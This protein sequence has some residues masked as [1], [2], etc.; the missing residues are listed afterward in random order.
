MRLIHGEAER[1][2][3]ISLGVVAGA[4]GVL[5]MTV[6]TRFPPERAVP[7]IAVAIALVMWQR[8]LLAWR[9]L[10]AGILLV[11]F[12]LPIRYTIPGNLPFELEPYRLLVA[13][14]L[15]GWVSALLV[16][17]RVRLRASGFEGPLLMFIVGAVAS[18]LVNWSQVTSLGVETNVTKS[19]TFL[20]SFVL[21]VYFVTSV[22]RSASD[23]NFVLRALVTCGAVVAGF[24]LFES[25]SGY[26]IFDHLSGAFSF[27]RSSPLPYTLQTAAANSRG[28]RLRV[29]ASSQSPIALSAL[30]VMLVPLAV[31]LART[32]GRRWLWWAAA[33]VLSLGAIATLSR[34]GVMM[35]IVV[36]GVFLWLRPVETRRLWPLLV[37]ALL[38][39]HLALPGSIGALTTAFLPA[40]GLVAQQQSGAGTHG[41]GRLADVGPTLK[42]W[43]RSPILG[44][45]YGTRVVDGPTPNASILDDE[46][47]GT[48]LETGLVGVLC[49]IWLYASVLRRLV[50]RAR[51]D[52]SDQALLCVG[53]TASILAYAVGMVTYDAFSFVQ[54]T[55]VL[56][57]LL[58]LSVAA[59][60]E[61][62]R[63]PRT[64][65]ASP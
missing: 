33:A 64:A 51:A 26:N 59:C 43:E 17:P 54:V 13:L 16:D 1:G 23:L 61:R 36:A 41:S 49:W 15:A 48:L 14:V 63:G 65:A 25:A 29:Y 6:L 42:Q 62:V 58:G 24:A 55:L 2:P 7:V 30:F 20:L 3:I 38:A 9:S 47:L 45:G 22:V 50:A 56:Y 5:A 19:L 52:R 31:Y 34:T 35:L 18:D 21:V 39:V 44:Q 28:G 4:V 10:V 32:Q 46:W 27:L 12:F 57:V 40:G 37:P 53:L 60:H 11:D 8:R